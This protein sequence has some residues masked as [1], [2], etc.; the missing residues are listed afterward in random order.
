[1]TNRMVDVVAEGC[2]AGIR[3]GGTVPEDMIARRLS[4]DLRWVVAGAPAYLAVFGVPVTP[5]GLARHRC[6]GVRLGND[7]IYKW[8]FQSPKGE[9]AVTV[10]S[11]IMADDTRATVAMA[12]AGAGL[13]YCP[14]PILTQEIECGALRL[15]LDDYAVM[16]P[17]FHMYY[18]KSLGF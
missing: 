13:I 5:D 6:L 10:P 11:R 2:D 17:G 18:T 16:G 1:M 7:R 14:E 15:V 4:A 8:E 12:R 3:Y 9:F